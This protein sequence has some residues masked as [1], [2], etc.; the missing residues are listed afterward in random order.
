M[1]E[2]AFNYKITSIDNPINP[3][4]DFDAWLSFDR[5]LGYTTNELLA[6]FDLSSDLFPESYN[7]FL[8]GLALEKMLDLFPYYVLVTKDTKIKPIAV[9]E[10]EKQ[11]K[12]DQNPL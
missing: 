11:F 2:N 1:I 8:Y 12:I 9:S 7:E 3:F 5:K 4:S 6:I 10:L